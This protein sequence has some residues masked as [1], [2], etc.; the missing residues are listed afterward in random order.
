[1]EA[2]G[3]RGRGPLRPPPPTSRRPGRLDDYDD[4]DLDFD[5]DDDDDY[6]Q[7]YYPEYD[8]DMRVSDRT[9]DGLGGTR[10]RVR[11]R[12]L[13][14]RRRSRE[15][16][17]RDKTR[18]R[19]RGGALPSMFTISE[20]KRRKE[21]DD[22]D[23]YLGLAPDDDYDDDYYDP[24]KTRSS[25]RQRKGYAY[26]YSGDDDDEYD[27]L[28]V[29][30][31]DSRRS[32]R[33]RS[34]TVGSPRKRSWEERALD[35]DRVPPRGAT[36]WGP[37]GRESG[38][39][40]DAQTKAA[41]DALL[42]IR[43]AK[44]YLEKKENMV[45]DAEEEVVALKADASVIERKLDAAKDGSRADKLSTELGYIKRDIEDA[46]RMLRLARAERDAALR[47]VDEI[48]SK[49]WALLNEYEA[50]VEFEEARQR[51]QKIQ[52]AEVYRKEYRT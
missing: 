13:E 12:V 8:V 18:G 30:G 14:R 2:R 21:A 10:D 22:Y 34:S 17:N 4:Y 3:G 29:D 7:D 36:S 19:G 41:M 6:Y 43:Q 26:K 15:R 51:K 23:R 45:L 5:F 38:D 50:S 31:I 42:E 46:A 49:H 48:K 37:N 40:V 11:D 47:A 25:S 27:A 1:L 16:S 20:L 28:D 35:M 33:R 52:D 39:G 9:R 32:P 44:K 24:L